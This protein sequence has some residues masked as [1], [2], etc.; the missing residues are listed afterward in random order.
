[1]GSGMTFL[2][3]S[4]LRVLL[5]AGHRARARGGVF[6]VASPQDAVRRVL[7]PA[8]LDAQLDVRPDVA[9]ALAD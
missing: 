7:E 4:G 6:R 3:S 8:G 2:D 9:G 1:M 5:Q